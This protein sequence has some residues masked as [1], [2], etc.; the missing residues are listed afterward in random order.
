MHL[1]IFVLICLTVAGSVACKKGGGETPTGPG[2]I[3]QPNTTI[4]YTTI[5]A[6]DAIGFGSSV[7]C[8]PF[9]DCANGRGYVQVLT[10]ELRTRGFR[11]PHQCP[12]SRSRL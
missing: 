3:P 5:G 6:S 7:P 8:L 9:N 10:R 11:E 1:N 12:I 2:P 4:H